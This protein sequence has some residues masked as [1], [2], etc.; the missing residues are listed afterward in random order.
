[1]AEITF[2]DKGKVQ[3]ITIS[4]RF[5]IE[6]K[7]QFQRTVKDRIS[8]E[9]EA[10]CILASDLKYIDSSGI[11]DL[12]KLKMEA[13][14]GSHTIYVVGLNES[15]QKVF[16]MARLDSVFVMLT[17]DDYKEKFG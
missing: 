5:T 6:D 4:G 10:S 14:K 1:M 2:E 16:T 7:D 9:K 15:I 13:A 11:G 8:F 17:P 12:L 3:V